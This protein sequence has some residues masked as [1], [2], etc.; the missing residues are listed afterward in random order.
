M[1]KVYHLLYK[2]NVMMKIN[3]RVDQR[4]G[5]ETAAPIRHKCVSGFS[6]CLR[7]LFG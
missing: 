1:Y 7:S 5:D 2:A 3:V 4:A 6:L